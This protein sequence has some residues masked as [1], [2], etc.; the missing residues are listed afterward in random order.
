MAAPPTSRDVVDVN[1]RY[2]DVAAH[3]Y[4]AKW[5]IDYGAVG[6]A[7]VLG[8]LT[9]LLGAHPGPYARSLEIGAGTG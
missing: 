9:K 7:Q 4:D 8:K 3:D 2:H 5:G 6:G 1:R